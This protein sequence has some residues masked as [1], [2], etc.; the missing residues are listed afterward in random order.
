MKTLL[1]LRH[2]K[3]DW[4]DP[5]LH[6]RSRPLAPRGKKDA[7]LMGRTLFWLKILPDLTL[8]SPAIRTQETAR[9]FLKKCEKS[10]NLTL[11]APLYED[12]E[13]AVLLE[14]QKT[15]DQ[16]QTLLL[17]GHNPLLEILV[18]KLVSEGSFDLK[19]PSASLVCLES[20]EI[21][22]RDTDWNNFSFQWV[23]HPRLMKK[24]I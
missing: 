15:S 19:L 22:W 9:R 18:S 20:K 12:D 4:S 6:D 21:A 23:L 8:C 2:A 7:S 11:S 13:E 24:L 1:V 17:V 10:G 14:I 5:L 3:S 16:I